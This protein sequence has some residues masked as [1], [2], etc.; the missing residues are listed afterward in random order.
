[1]DIIHSATCMLQK[2]T[3]KYLKS[4]PVLN[5]TTITSLTQLTPLNKICKNR[6][7][8]LKEKKIK[9]WDVILYALMTF[10]TNISRGLPAAEIIYGTNEYI[11]YRPG[12]TN[13]IISVPHDGF[14]MPGKL[15]IYSSI[16]E[17]FLH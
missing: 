8:C 3:Y 6:S 11:E 5:K 10:F 7:E 16:R 17:D 13:L 9:M 2:N 12:N 4:E 1:M 15:F 14:Y